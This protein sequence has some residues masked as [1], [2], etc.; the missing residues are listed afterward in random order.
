M[1]TNLG[2]P[3]AATTEPHLEDILAG[4]ATRGLREEKMSEEEGLG[5]SLEFR[6]P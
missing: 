1:Q 2:C 3:T 6:A 5:W 4:A